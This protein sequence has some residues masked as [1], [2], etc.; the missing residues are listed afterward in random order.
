MVYQKSPVWELA[1]RRSGGSSQAGRRRYVGVGS[2]CFCIQFQAAFVGTGGLNKKNYKVGNARNKYEAN[3]ISIYPGKCVTT[4]V[5]YYSYAR[6]IGNTD[7]DTD[8]QY[9][10]A[11]SFFEETA[12]R[13]APG[14]DQTHVP[15]RRD[16]CP[17]HPDHGWLTEEQIESTY[18][19]LPQINFLSPERCRPH[20]IY[21]HIGLNK[22][23]YKVGNANN[24]SI[25]VHNNS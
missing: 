14:E 5:I 8:I 15:P 11:A 18:S 7:S 4:V 10:Q 13:L 12:Q 19:I 2:F 21:N 6:Y 17:Y 23:N 22:K 20:N 9:R 1:G 3:N 25:Y 16:E 24:I